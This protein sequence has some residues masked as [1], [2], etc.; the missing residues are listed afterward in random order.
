MNYYFKPELETKNILHYAHGQ[1]G[2]VVT[3][4]GCPNQIGSHKF[5]LTPDSILECASNLPNIQIGNDVSSNITCLNIPGTYIL[6]TNVSAAA[7]GGDLDCTFGQSVEIP[8]SISPELPEDCIVDTFTEFGC[9]SNFDI[10]SS[11]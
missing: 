8:Y 4:E 5:K 10:C 2:L 1:Y 3:L 7:F 6:T 9:S 11:K